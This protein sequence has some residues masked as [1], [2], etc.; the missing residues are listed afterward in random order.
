MDKIY[1]DI[2]NKEN[3]SLE[4]YIKLNNINVIHNGY[5][6][7][8]Y[9]IKYDNVDAFL[10]LTNNYIDINIKDKLGN[11]PLIYSIIYNKLNFFKVLIKLKVNINLP[12][13][14]NITP[15]IYALENDRV[16]MVNILF[17]NNVDINN[18]QYYSKLCFSVIKSHNMNLVKK[19]ITKELFL[20]NLKDINGN[21]LLHAACKINDYNIVQYLVLDLKHMTNIKNNYDETP[22]FIAVRSSNKSIISFLMDN[23]ALI[24]ILNIFFENVYDIASKDIYDFLEFKFNNVNYQKYIKDFKFHSYVIKND[25]LKVKQYI[26]KKNIKLID[27]F[28]YLAKDYAN[29]LNHYDILRLIEK[30]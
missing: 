23:G 7:L 13:D 30:Y 27:S 29:L 17:E 12:N 15:L 2:I 5:S 4:H 9:A 21:S 24:D 16:D 11:T 8:H 10:L 22:L 19:I 28:G 20:H 3:Q 25:Y 26:S 14:E 6:L 1:N 18:T